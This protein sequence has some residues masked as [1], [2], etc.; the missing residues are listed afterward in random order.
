MIKLYISKLKNFMD[1]RRHSTFASAIL[2]VFSA[3]IA[4]ESHEAVADDLK[5]DVWENNDSMVWRSGFG[6]CWRSGF[7][8]TERNMKCDPQHVAVAETAV[9]PAPEPPVQVVDSDTGTIL[10][11]IDG[12]HFAFD[13]STLRD[14]AKSTLDE[15]V[16]VLRDNRDSN[17]AIVGHTDSI[18]SDAYNNDLSDRRARAVYDYLAARDV[19]S[20]RLTVYGRGESQPIASNQTDAGRAE[21]RRVD[22]I[23]D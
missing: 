6:E 2:L 13:K 23:V 19:N 4:M 7:P 21:N 16:R 9:T 11:T 15:A 22:F 3:G 18:G 8:D 12:V 5:L 10:Y 1:L 17:V 20:S 14:S